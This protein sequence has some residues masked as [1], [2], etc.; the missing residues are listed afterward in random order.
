VPADHKWYRNW[1]VAQL[2]TEVMDEMGLRYPEPDL[3][4]EAERAR[5][6]ATLPT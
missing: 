2:L 3:D 5:V 1:A 4:L 6:K